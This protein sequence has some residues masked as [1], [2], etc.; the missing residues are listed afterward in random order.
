[1]MK[2][3][4]LVLLSG[5]NCPL[6][7]TMKNELSA[8]KSP[9]PFEINEIDIKAHPQLEKEYWDRIPYLFVAGRPFAKGR[10]HQPKLQLALVAAK[11]G[12]RKGHLPTEVEEALK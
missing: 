12:F 9:L 8:F 4:Q 2:P 11:A 7:D 5:T 10:L 1:M 6:C 3:I